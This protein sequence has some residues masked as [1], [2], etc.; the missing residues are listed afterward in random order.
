MGE[1]EQNIIDQSVRFNLPLP[2][3]IANKPELLAGLKLYLA[4]FID[5]NSD[6][7]FNNGNPNPLPWS[8]IKDYGMFYGFDIDELVYFIRRMDEA[9]LKKVSK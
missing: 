5:L 2:D 4:S 9:F 1:I 7:T 8:L 3:R 6:R